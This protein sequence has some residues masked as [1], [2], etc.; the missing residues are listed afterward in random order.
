MK[1]SA[2]VI[3]GLALAVAGCS[4]SSN[5]ANQTSS[6]D[7]NAAAPA[8]STAAAETSAPAAQ[9][10]SAAIPVYPGAAK[11]AMLG[12]M[13][14][15]KCG[16]K[17]SVTTYTTSDDPKTVLAWYV[18]RVPGGIQVDAG[19]ALKTHMLMTSTEIFSPDGAS[20]VGV[21][22]PNAAAMGGKPQPVYIGIGSYDPP[23]SADEMHTMED[24]MGTDPA[25]KQKAIAAMKAKCGPDSVKAFE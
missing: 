7:T 17:E 9:A 8:A 12:E 25:A 15:T 3:L 1:P 11:S 21:T 20:A 22:Q 18:Q 4:G 16:H 14:Q 24:I 5:T 23:F 2:L 13:H 6:Q 19:R 10:A